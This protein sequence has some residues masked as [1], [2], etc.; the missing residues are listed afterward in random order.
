MGSGLP[1]MKSQAVLAH[2]ISI[3]RGARSLGVQEK[4]FG[5]KGVPHH[6]QAFSG[7]G[8]RLS[9]PLLYRRTRPTAVAWSLSPVLPSR[10]GDASEPTQSPISIGQSPSR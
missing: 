9:C 7:A 10:F 1:P 5:V 3:F 8:A 6:G 2:R 4:E